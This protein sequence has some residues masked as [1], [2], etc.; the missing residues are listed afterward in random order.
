[1]TPKTELQT[2][3]PW[4]R[5]PIVWLMVGLPLVSVV[6]GFAM[7]KL[8]VSGADLLVMEAPQAS[9]STGGAAPALKARNHA[10][11]GVQ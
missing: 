8:A 10:A 2:S 6:A 3:E 5:Y 1:M 11:T 7:L 9:T 4:W